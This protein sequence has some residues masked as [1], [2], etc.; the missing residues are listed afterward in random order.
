M[1]GVHPVLNQ[2]RDMLAKALAGH[3]A[4]QLARH[5]AGDGARW[6]ACQVMEHLRATWRL[7]TAGL[8]DRL[9][10]GR[11][12]QT[13]PTLSQRWRQVV[14]CD[15]GFFPRGREAPPPTRPAAAPS[16]EMDG[17][18]LIACMH[19]D[20]A[21]LDG[22]LNRMEPAAGGKVAL[23][24]MMLGPLTVSQWRRFHRVHARHHLRQ[25]SAALGKR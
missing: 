7:T 5:P 11:P 6:S 17:D 23:T 22:A 4:E 9:R 18:A 8:E 20:L 25:I 3:T 19:E 15:L 12:L 13:R 10:K 2:T 14:I 16:P 24:H 1:A 21:A